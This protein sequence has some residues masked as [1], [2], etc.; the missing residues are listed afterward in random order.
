M[1]EWRV[2]AVLVGAGPGRPDLITVRGREWIGRADVILYDRL[3][4][5]R[6]LAYSKAECRTVF[7]GKECGRHAFE[8]DEI[9]RM[10]VEEARAGH[11]V[12]R[13]KGGDPGVF[14]RGGEEAEALAREGIPFEIVPGVTAG[15]GAAAY[16]GV[17]LTHRDRASA[18]QFSTGRP[19]GKAAGMTRV[20]Y[21]AGK[22][23]AAATADLL[24]AGLPPETPALAIEA[25]TWDR[26]RSL[27]TT[28]GR[29]PNDVT[30]DS[31]LLIIVGDVVRERERTNWFERRPLHGRRILVPRSRDHEGKLAAL[32]SEAGAEPVEF[33]PVTFQP[34]EALSGAIQDLP[35]FSG[36]HFGDP[37]AADLFMTELRD[38]RKLAD[39][40]VS[41]AGHFTACAL[42]R[43]GLVPDLV[44]L[45]DRGPVLWLGPGELPEGL[46]ATQVSVYQEVLKADER[47]RIECLDV[48][49]A[50]FPSS[51]S[52]RRSTELLGRT[53]LAGLP[54]F[55]MGE[56]TSVELVR[57]GL[58]PASEA[59]P[60]T[61]EGMVDVVV[62][63]FTERA[64]VCRASSIS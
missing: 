53:Y 39:F 26:Q 3:I 52:V 32:L 27:E 49:G 30:F 37:Q 2:R 51:A 13:L 29:L 38:A 14:G 48:H 50:A 62:R 20:L 59:S 10:M 34:T 15:V 35:S 36:V 63:H 58:A 8:E 22:N 25:G 60:S 55:S 24:A 28:L 9:I 64:A 11:L 7:V 46:E 54:L 18:V 31:P 57:R 12:V 43:R 4:D 6:L 42:E 17:P 47:K 19:A 5:P 61:F 16:A 1:S 23:L 40:R 41:A 21:M 45:P 56:E 33:T 44:G